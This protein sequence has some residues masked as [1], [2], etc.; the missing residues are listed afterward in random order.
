MRRRGPPATLLLCLLLGVACNQPPGPVLAPPFEVA[1]EEELPG[2]TL[3]EDITRASGVRHTYRNGEDTANHLAILESL[4]GGVALIDY[5]GDGLLD[6]FIPGGGIFT[7]KD[8]K[9][10]T[11]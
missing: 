8:R 11:G 5:D 6:I 2:P 10:I 4:G 1:A 9:D 7:G 3:F